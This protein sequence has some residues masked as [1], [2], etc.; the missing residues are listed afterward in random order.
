MTQQEGPDFRAL[1]EEQLQRDESELELDL[2]ALYLAGEEYPTL[3][4]AHYLELLDRLATDVDEAA[5]RTGDSSTLVDLLNRHLF[6]LQA[7]S[8]N[9]A[10]YNNPDNSFL[11]RVLDTRLGI[12]ITLSI[13][14]LELCRRL[15]ISARGVGL[16]GHF[17]VAIQDMDLYLDPFHG[18]QLLSASDC[19]R[20]V[21]D[22]FGPLF[23]WRD[24]FLNTYT[25]RDILFRVMSNLKAIYAQSRD[26][27]R[28]S[29]TLQQMLL[30]H[31]L[32]WI[33]RELA[34]CY[35]QMKDKPNAI[36][37]I[38]KYLVLVKTTQDTEVERQQ[39]LSLW[40]S[41]ARLG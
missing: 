16:P 26:Y 34:W 11:N 2:A 7:F 4:V 6:D 5:A 24:E 31:P 12:P 28:W 21:L 33:Y 22:L 1:L 14:Y 29:V 3:D 25:K 41:I 37:S 36:Q 18:G 32:P 15:G 30:I 9:T 8:G 19:R 13:V 27:R 20:L 38:E 17:V 40:N 10:Q 39:M 35:Y 23:P